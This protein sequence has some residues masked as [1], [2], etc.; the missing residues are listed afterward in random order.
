MVLAL[1]SCSTRM[2]MARAG[3]KKLATSPA[4]I[5]A[6]IP[7]VTDEEC[8]DVGRKDARADSV[9]Q[10]DHRHGAADGPHCRGDFGADKAAAE[11][12]EAQLLIRDRAQSGVVVERAV[13][14][15]LAG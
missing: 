11:D 3:L 5:A 10:H 12:D 14:N 9:F 2:R 4:A 7:L 13:V 15:D 1:C 6:L 8:R